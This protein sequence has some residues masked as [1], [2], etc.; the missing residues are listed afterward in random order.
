MALICAVPSYAE[1]SAATGHDV[2]VINGLSAARLRLD[3]V[4]PVLCGGKLFFRA[5][6]SGHT[7]T[8]V[9]EGTHLSRIGDFLVRLNVTRVSDD[10]G[11]EVYL[12][13]AQAHLD[14]M[15]LLD[16]I[17]RRELIAV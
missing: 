16:S 12:A 3:E 15:E 8:P 1:L 13:H 14:E 7:E 9:R 4:A 10:E 17:A 5:T 6:L 2:I 11:I